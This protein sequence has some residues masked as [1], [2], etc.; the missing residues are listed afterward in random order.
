MHRIFLNS[1]VIGLFWVAAVNAG[2]LFPEWRGIDGQG[3]ADARNLPVEFSES[4]AAWKYKVP[5]LGWSTPVIVDGKVWVTTGLDKEASEE[6]KVAPKVD[7][8]R[9]V[10]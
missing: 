3:H 8:F 10:Y 4:D 6:R 9:Q 5:G 1:V 2:D 7:I